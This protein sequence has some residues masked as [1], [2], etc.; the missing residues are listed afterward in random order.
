MITVGIDVVSNARD[1]RDSRDID[2]KG[3]M[4]IKDSNEDVEHLREIL[5][6]DSAKF[7]VDKN[8]N[9]WGGQMNQIVT[10]RNSKSSTLIMLPDSEDSSLMDGTSENDTF[11]V[12]PA[13]DL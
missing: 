6:I 7:N 5:D 3:L 10:K 9:L 8:I 13:E 2:S 11:R 4:G 12:R 1:N